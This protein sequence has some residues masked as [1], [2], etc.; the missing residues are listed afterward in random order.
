MLRLTV[1]LTLLWLPNLL[2]QWDKLGEFFV[3]R[4]QLI[5]LTGLLGLAYMSVAVLLVA[6]FRWVEKMVNGLDQGYKLHKKLGIG[7]A[8]ALLLHWLTVQ[9]A[10]WMVGAG[11][12]ERP[13]RGPRAIVEGIQWRPIAEQVGELAF[14]V[15]LIFSVIS[16]V[17]AISYK[18][19]KFTHKLG[20]ALMVAGIFHTLLLLDWTL[21]AIP[22]NMTIIALCLAGGVG[23]WLS[24]TGRIGRK[25]KADGTVVEVKPFSSQAK[26]LSH[27]DAIRITIQ[28]TSG[29]LYKEGQFAYLNFHDGESPHPFSILNYDPSTLRIEFGIKSLGDYTHDL[30]NTLAAEQGVTVEGGYGYFQVPQS[31]HQIWVG[32]GIGI[33]PFISRLYWLKAQSNDQVSRINKIHLFYCVQSKKEAFFNHEIMMLL[34]HLSFVELHVVDAER[35]EFLDSTQVLESFTSESFEV[36]FCGPETFGDSLK[37]GLVEAG[38]PA[39]RFH[40]EAFKMR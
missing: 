33:V 4:H 35:G 21:V 34:R 36:S 2:I 18:K 20:G 7:A 30:V 1:L 22:Q 9:S 38:L 31:M 17:Q 3:W 27:N 26:G 11:M 16:L 37:S 23:S 25:N 39:N 32:A 29:I 8:V 24:L 14:Y 40:Q 10:K 6:R 13:H 28:L 5:M 15:L 12:I 19:F